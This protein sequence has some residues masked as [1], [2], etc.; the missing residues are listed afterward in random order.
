[1][2]EE[3]GD[4]QNSLE[5]LKRGM[6]YA[7]I[8]NCDMN[9]EMRSDAVDLVISATEK[10]QANYEMAARMVK[11]QVRLRNVSHV[12]LACPV[13][14]SLSLRERASTCPL[15]PL[16]LSHRH[17]R[18]CALRWTRSTTR[19]GLSRLGRASPLR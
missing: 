9:E 6:Q 11:D 17:R 12:P 4:E 18:S 7:L 13:L 15:S 5:Q 3:G 14:L 10:Y 19:T 16:F 1:M 8:K 2:A